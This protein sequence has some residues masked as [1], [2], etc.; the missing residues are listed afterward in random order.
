MSGIGV[1]A[2]LEA[3]ATVGAGGAT[4]VA[5]AAARTGCVSRSTILSAHVASLFKSE[6]SKTA[7]MTCVFAGSLCSHK[8]LNILSD[9]SAPASVRISLRSADGVLSPSSISPISVRNCFSMEC[10]NL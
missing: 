4:G 2:A 10:V 3:A 5:V 8:V 6:S 9:T 7:N 1:D